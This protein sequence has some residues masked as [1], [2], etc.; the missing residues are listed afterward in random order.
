[1][2]PLQIEGKTFGR[3]TVAE[4]SGCDRKGE[5]LWRCTCICGNDKLVNTWSLTSGH[6]RSCGCM[7][8]DQA[9]KM[10]EIRVSNDF[11]AGEQEKIEPCDVTRFGSEKNSNYS[12]N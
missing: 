3:L 12:P 11:L 8:A 4:R 10:A 2:R 7:R 6:T 9:R 5:A 1:M